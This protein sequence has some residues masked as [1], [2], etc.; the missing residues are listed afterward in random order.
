MVDIFQTIALICL[1]LKMSSNPISD[2]SDCNDWND[3][4]TDEWTDTFFAHSQSPRSDS[5]ASTPKAGRRGMSYRPDASPRSDSGDCDFLQ[6]DEVS[7]FLTQP[8]NSFVDDSPSMGEGHRSPQLDSYDPRFESQSRKDVF[9]SPHVPPHPGSYDFPHLR[10]TAE[11]HRATTSTPDAGNPCRHPQISP[12]QSSPPKTSAVAAAA[13]A[14]VLSSSSRYKRHS[15]SP[16]TTSQFSAGDKLDQEERIDQ[17]RKQHRSSPR[18]LFSLKTPEQATKTHR[19]RTPCTDMSM[20]DMSMTPGTPLS[21]DR[22]GFDER[23][24]NRIT[25]VIHAGGQRRL[26]SPHMSRDPFRRRSP[27]ISKHKTSVKSPVFHNSPGFDMTTN[28]FGLLDTPVPSTLGGDFSPM[29]PSFAGLDYDVTRMVAP[30]SVRQRDSSIP[31]RALNWSHSFEG[32]D[33]K[34]DCNSIIGECSPSKSAF[35]SPYPLSKGFSPGESTASLS[36]MDESPLV[37]SRSTFSG[38]FNRYSEASHSARYPDDLSS[39]PPLRVQSDPR[40]KTKSS[41]SDNSRERG[42]QPVSSE[43]RPMWREY[44]ESSN[45]S[46]DVV[47]GSQNST[48]QFNHINSMMRVQSSRASST[49]FHFQSPIEHSGARRHSSVYDYGAAYG[50]TH[51]H[52]TIPT[53]HAHSISY[54]QVPYTSSEPCSF[55]SVTP[56]ATAFPTPSVS[57]TITAKAYASSAV[58]NSTSSKKFAKHHDEAQASNDGTPMLENASNPH[59]STSSI[60][61]KAASVESESKGGVTSA[62]DSSGRNPCHCKKSRCLKLYCECFSN[63]VFCDGCSCLDCHNTSV[64][65]TIRDR[66]IRETKAKNP[67]AFKSRFQVKEAELQGTFNQSEHTIGCKC[68]N[69]KCLKK[70]CE[71]RAQLVELRPIENGVFFS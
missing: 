40:A 57:E 54:G 41:S 63:E 34:N 30:N 6:I 65:A 11:F 38:S 24:G 47:F 44:F 33:E 61:P 1:P 66:A 10:A 18:S 5:F 26:L 62:G 13:A 64:T 36:G 49:G 52:Q 19:S 7:R 70:Y 25:V 39:D 4:V 21:I 69:S 22:N 51:Y 8:I 58:E 42:T 71:V 29:G 35:A 9:P 3:D 20:T 68:K 14:A 23:N 37:T 50:A 15:T 53:A 16:S 60:P 12:F 43:P 48:S 46:S 32:N 56:Q 28:S 59:S 67:T 17:M 31:N 2:S 45:T 55:P 27:L